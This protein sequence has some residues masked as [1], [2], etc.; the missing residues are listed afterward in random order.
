MK[1]PR[2]TKQ[3]GRLQLIIL[4]PVVL[5]FGYLLFGKPYWANWQVFASGTVTVLAVVY[6]LWL[7][8][9]LI[10]LRFHRRFPHF[11]QT[12]RRVVLTTA[13]VLVID[14]LV[15]A[16]LF[17]GIGYGG[18]SDYAI[19]NLPWAWLCSGAIIVVV[20][21]LYES[22]L[23]F[24]HWQRALVETER[25]QKVNLQSQLEALKQQ[26]NPHFLF[27]SLNVLDSLIED[28]PRQASAFLDQL[29]T[30]YR[31]LL[32]SNEQNL[33]DLNTELQFIK[34]YFHLLRTRHGVGLNLTVAVDE[35]F[36]RYQ[37]PP[38]TLQLLVENAVKHNVILREQPLTI[39]ILTD[40]QAHLLVRNNIQQKRTRVV[41]NGV[42]LSNILTK[43]RMLNQP[44][45]TVWE[46]DG[47][48]VVTLPL[49]ENRN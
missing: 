27:N 33:A 41:S 34:S 32:R 36:G 24:G 5:T 49:I 12:L 14:N 11:R 26:V 1:L 20:V 38:L 6:G 13:V 18:L 43:Y 48:F 15:Y 28:D 8:N 23:A 42:G 37:L 40:A 9:N 47:Q 3:D 17:L 22:I 29:S 19:P 2:Y 35:R 30:V 25:L 44:V 21:A 31:Y 46:A 10:A 16:A 4:P 39:E 45:P 7:T